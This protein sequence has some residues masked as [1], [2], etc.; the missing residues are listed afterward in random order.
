MIPFV[1][2]HYSFQDREKIIKNVY[3][4]LLTR[5]RKG[6]FLYF[7]HDPKLD[8]AFQRFTNMLQI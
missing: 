3:R 7:P 6:M 5:S 4:V 8:E 1:S 2:T